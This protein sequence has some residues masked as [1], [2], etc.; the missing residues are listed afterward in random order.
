MPASDRTVADRSP[1]GPS[2]KG[3]GWALWGGLAVMGL[4]P[5]LALFLVQPPRPVARDVSQDRFS[6]SRAE[7]FLDQLVADGIPHPAGSAQNRLVRKKIVRLLESF[8]YSV[9]LQETESQIRRR[10]LEQEPTRLPIC[11]VMTRLEGVSDDPAIMLVTHFDSVPY[12]PGASD[13]GV[14]VAA[15]LEVARMLKQKGPPRRTV[16]FLFTDGEEYGLLGAEKFIEEH[17]W[18]EQVKWVINLEARGTEGPSVMFE[19]GTE[20]LSLVREFASVSRRP[21]SSSLFFEIYKR[22]PNDT[23][24]SVFKKAGMQGYNFAFIGN[25]KHYHTPQDNIANVDRASFQHHGENMW[26]LVANLAYRDEMPAEQGRA[27]YFDVFG[28]VLVWWP[29]SWSL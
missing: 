28:R 21:V 4:I 12:G 29:V 13:D 2:L 3:G 22:L 25:V 14:G 5:L 24:F 19:T 27:V 9:T 18:A 8:G 6:A 20:S 17:P 1:N 16:V 23:D 7:V 10:R 11:N 15:M 26:R